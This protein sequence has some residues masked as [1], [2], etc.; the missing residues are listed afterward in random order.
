MAL[1][2]ALRKKAFEIACIL[3]SCLVKFLAD[4]ENSLHKEVL[5]PTECV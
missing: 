1:L 5:H 4:V 2:I 3:E